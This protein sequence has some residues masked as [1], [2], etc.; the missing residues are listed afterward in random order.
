MI[1]KNHNTNWELT[2]ACKNTDIIIPHIELPLK[3]V[4][5]EIKIKDNIL[6]CRNVGGYYKN[7]KILNGYL[8]L[9]LN[10]QLKPF[11][12]KTNVEFD[13]KD[14]TPLLKKINV[15]KRIINELGKIKINAGNCSGL[16]TLNKNLD[17]Y[18]W[19]VITKKH[20]GKWQDR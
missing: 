2:G 15:S 12:I 3:K 13:L 19:K 6:E 8:D 9:G 11:I 20:Q 7:S 14:L 16:F 17:Q 5:G 4:S 18:L 10:S 1:H